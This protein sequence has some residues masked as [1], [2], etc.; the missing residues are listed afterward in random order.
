MT[1]Y[2]TLAGDAVTQI[3]AAGDLESLESLRSSLLGKKAPL[4]L[5]KKDL[6][7][8]EPEQRKE[9]GQAINAARQSVEDAFSARHADLAAAARAV[10]LDAEPVSYTHLTLPT[11]PYV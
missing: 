11:T 6:G 5:A 8:L 3:E 4:S 1:S 10:A 2:E 9:A 7:A